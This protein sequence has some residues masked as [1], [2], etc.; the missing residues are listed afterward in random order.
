MRVPAG[1]SPLVA[2]AASVASRTVP[3]AVIP[4]LIVLAI[5]AAR[6]R[7]FCHWV[8]PTGL[9]ADAASA[10]GSKLGRRCPRSPPLGTWILWITLGGAIAGYPLLLWLDP[11]AILTSFV[12]VADWPVAPMT[13][14]S[15]VAGA[16]V[17]LVSLIF[18]RLWCTRLCPAGALQDALAW[19]G[20]WWRR[21][22]GSQVQSS[23]TRAV[24][25]VTRRAA[26]LT[27]L[28]IGWV[29]LVSRARAAAHRPVRP[30]GAIPETA[31]AGV[32]V[33]CGNCRRVCPSAVIE[34]EMGQ[35]GLG[36]FL[37]P[38]VQF[39]DDY[40]REDCTRCSHVCPSGAL[41]PVEVDRKTF[42]P[43]GI[44]RVDMDVCLLGE[45]RDCAACR[46]HCPYEAIRFV[47][48]EETYTLT[49]HV[50]SARCPGCGACEAVCPT[51]PTRAI[52]VIAL[53]NS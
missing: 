19:P 12:A 31:F 38:M 37:T 51:R 24:R 25:P 53:P 40:C 8:C 11:L 1:A 18:P 48:C 50:D 35:G 9:C 34:P 6:R 17:L 16:G 30:P 45:N 36:T 7:W 28:G 29:A 33:R 2:L 26:L 42:A 47:F 21:D 23:G 32:C 10:L 3:A 20:I 27:T 52:R 13:L 15:A 43:M 39:S 44:A 5:V 41:L 22:R 14:W 4:G 49:P 46:S